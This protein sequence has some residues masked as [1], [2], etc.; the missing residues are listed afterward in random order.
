[1]KAC[2]AKLK[3]LRNPAVSEAENKRLKEK[4]RTNKLKKN[5]AFLISLSETKGAFFLL[6]INGKISG[7][8]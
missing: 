5:W 3:L 1:M 4:G 8:V 7:K 2:S 6:S